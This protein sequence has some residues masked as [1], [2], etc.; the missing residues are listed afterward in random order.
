[1][2]KHWVH[3]SCTWRTVHKIINGGAVKTLIKSHR[4]VNLAFNAWWLLL[5]NPNPKTTT[6]RAQSYSV[7]AVPHKT[8]LHW[9]PPRRYPWPSPP[10]SPPL[11]A[12]D[13]FPTTNVFRLF[14]NHRCYF[15]ATCPRFCFFCS[16]RTSSIFYL[17][18]P[19]QAASLFLSIFSFIVS[20][21][22]IWCEIDICSF[23]FS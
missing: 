9:G 21:L 11:S 12:S 16:F 3:C 23:F 7:L 13:R 19:K 8:Q 2:W 22:S 15:G 6:S 18:P 4:H 10:Y 1:M 5:P 17:L 20:Y 14:L